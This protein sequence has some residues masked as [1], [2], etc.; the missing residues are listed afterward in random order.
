MLNLVCAPVRARLFQVASRFEFPTSTCQG[1]ESERR[2]AE[3]LDSIIARLQLE[4]EGGSL[5][6]RVAFLAVVREVISTTQCHYPITTTTAVL[7]PSLSLSSYLGVIH[8][9]I[10]ATTPYILLSSTCVIM[11]HYR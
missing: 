2:L 8:Y 6:A 1:R 4:E 5:D 11:Y 10:T 7:L 9:H 3:V